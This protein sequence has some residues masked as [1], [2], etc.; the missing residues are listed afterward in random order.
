MNLQEVRKAEQFINQGVNRI[1]VGIQSLN[2]KTLQMLNRGYESPHS[3]PKSELKGSL[4]ALSESVNLNLDFIVD[5]NSRAKETEQLVEFISYVKPKHVSLYMLEINEGSYLQKHPNKF[6]NKLG[7]N[8]NY[9]QLSNSLSRQLGY[10]HYEVSNYC[11]PGFRSKHNTAY[12][13]GNKPFGAFGMGATSLLNSHRITRPRNLS[14][15]Y[16]YVNSLDNN[17]T[18]DSQ[19]L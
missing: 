6:I 12:W 13:M 16:N 2:Q 11:L 9:E 7:N 8:Q 3:L 19:I 18:S 14:K 17:L 15:Y 1:S 10:Q 5:F 4:R